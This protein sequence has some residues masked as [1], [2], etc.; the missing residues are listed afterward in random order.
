MLNDEGNDNVDK[1]FLEEQLDLLH[2]AV[3]RLGGNLHF[4]DQKLMEVLNKLK[5]IDNQLNQKF[6]NVVDIHTQ[7]EVVKPN[8]ASWL[9]RKHREMQKIYNQVLA[10]NVGESFTL[11]GVEAGDRVR[12]SVRK[13]NSLNGTDVKVSVKFV[14]KQNGSVVIRIR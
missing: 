1:D 11:A 9:A 12:R 2:S 10:M 6:N 8:S 3:S 4:I 13:F 14:E 7:K 5:D